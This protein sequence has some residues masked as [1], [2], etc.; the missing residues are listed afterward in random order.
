MSVGRDRRAHDQLAS[1]EVPDER[2]EEPRGFAA[3]DAAMV[4]GER[5]RHAQVRFDAA[6]HGDD[7]VTQLAGA[8][9]RHRGRHDDGRGVAARRS[10]RSSTA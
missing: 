2:R 4:E 1:L 10:C 6:H 5:Q 7:V 8:E 3:G 9:N